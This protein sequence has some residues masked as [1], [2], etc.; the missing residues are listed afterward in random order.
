MIFFIA[1]TVGFNSYHGCMKCTVIGEYDRKGR[2]MSF[3]RTDMPLRT[4]HSF[5][6]RLDP[7]H[8]K[9][10]SPIEDLPIDL[11]NDFTI[12]DALHL[13]DLGVMKRCLLGWTNGSFNFQTKWSAREIQDVSRKLMEIKS[14]TPSEIHQGRLRELDTLHFWKGTEFKNFLLYFGPVVLKEHLSCEVY[15]HFLTLFCA[16]TI[17][18][19]DVYVSY[20]HIA[21]K[22]FVDYIEKFAE[23]YG[24]DSVS[25]NIHNLCHIVNDVSRF[26]SLPSLSAYPFES[27]LFRIK[28]LLRKGDQPLAQVANRIQE[29]SKLNIKDHKSKRMYPLVKYESLLDKGE[30]VF[31]TVKMSENYQL[32]KYMKDKWFLTT[33]NNIV[34]MKFATFDQG[35]IQIVGRNIK[36]KCNFFERPFNSSHINIYATLLPYELEELKKY[37]LNDV[38][39]KLTSMVSNSQMVFIPVLT[40]LGKKIN[41]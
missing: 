41:K 13:L 39:C 29:L 21:E 17:C 36:N 34:E 15:Q 35:N 12:A 25:S 32:S 31:T 18:Y 10:K 28:N 23:I 5:R 8:H 14:T 16:A 20:R 7:D 1:G 2:H 9:E 4:D 33:D 6:N 19:S 40:T 37:N 24:H 38:K 22:L 27:M 26:G 3:P 11:V 30:K